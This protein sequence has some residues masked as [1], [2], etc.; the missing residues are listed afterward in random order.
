[1]TVLEPFRIAAY[2]LFAI[3]F[4]ANYW[5][6]HKF[7]PPSVRRVYVALVVVE[8]ILGF[9]DIFRDYLPPFWAW[10]FYIHSELNG[11]AIFSSIQLLAVGIAA[12][13]IAFLATDSKAWHRLFWLVLAATFVYLSADEFFTVHEALRDTIGLN[14]SKLVY[15]VGGGV[16]A[17]SIAT[18]FWFG[19]RKEFKNF[20]LIL[21]GLGSI[22]GSGLGY[23][24]LMGIFI[25]G[26]LPPP[27]DRAYVYGETL[28][29]FG[30]TLALA[31][32]LMHMELHLN[33]S[34][35]R[36]AKQVMWGGFA[37]GV[38]FCLSYTWLLP[39]IELRALAEQVDVQ[40]DE[41]AMTLAGYRTTSTTIEGG[42]IV[43]VT[44][45]WKAPQ[46]L[47]ANYNISAHLVG[48]PEP[49]SIAQ[50]DWISDPGLSV[51]VTPAWLPGV[52][53]R[54][55]LTLRLPKGVPAPHSYQIIVRVWRPEDG[56]GA[57]VSSTTLPLLAEDTVILRH[58]V[59]LAPVETQPPIQN[60]FQVG[61][62][63]T[64]LGYLLPTRTEVGQDFQLGFWWQKTGA[65]ATDPV[66]FI[67]LKNQG[68][69]SVTFSHDQQ[70]F[71]GGFPIS[72]WPMLVNLADTWSVALP[73]DLPPGDYIV[74]TGL[75]E[76]PSLARLSVTDSNH[77]AV[78][79][80]IIPLG[81]VTIE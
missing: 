61:D 30:A 64:L 33:P 68:D 27:C 2:I 1:M 75:Y 31:G 63:L 26:V 23:E 39:A 11:G 46:T 7:M 60:R 57:P 71:G 29:A 78:A 3:F 52:P 25:C 40:F 10:F 18:M 53:V 44:L 43:G 47:T 50:D 49:N 15:V 74:S 69:T 32:V 38:L 58:V 70:P 19:Y 28:E 79:D 65:Y 16:L 42:D 24:P 59:A 80:N 54:T 36:Q 8:V 55:N 35:S 4:I 13:T 76:W 14:Q 37:T 9:G 66:Q 77:E 22:G 21:I 72:D 6:A 12:A 17:G 56:N 41:G 73:A 45:Y 5:F 67:H 34:R 20:A 81:T 62:S 51:Y 48:L